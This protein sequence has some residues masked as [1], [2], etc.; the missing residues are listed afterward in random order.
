MN[1]PPTITS[2]ANRRRT[3]SL[4]NPQAPLLGTIG[5]RRNDRRRYDDNAQ[6][7]HRM[8]SVTKRKC[9]NIYIV[10]IA[11]YASIVALVYFSRHPEG[12]VGPLPD[13]TPGETHPEFFNPHTAWEHL[14]NI[15]TI[16]HAFNSRANT[17]VTRRYIVDQLK[18]LQQ[19]A[20]MLGRRNVRYDDQDTTSIHRIVKSK[21]QMEAEKDNGIDSYRDDTLESETKLFVQ[22]DNLL[23]WVGGVIP[24]QG[25]SP[26][27][28]I[29]FE[30]E[31]NALLVSSH[32][33]SVSTSYGATDDGGGVAVS[34][35]LIQHFIHHPVQHT[36]IFFFNNAEE[37]GL[38]GAETFM[39]ARDNKTEEYGAGHPWK[40]YIKAFINL[41]GGG[42]GGPSLLF[43][44]TGNDI[45][46]HYAANAP[47]PHAS[48]FANDLFATGIIDSDTDFT[49]YKKH[50]LP[51]LDIAF[52]QRRAMYHSTTDWLP[53]QSLHHMGSNAQATIR[54]ICNSDYLDRLV[55]DGDDIFS[56]SIEVGP[57]EDGL[58]ILIGLYRWFSGLSIYY[59]IFGRRMIV[60]EL[61]STL[62][63][64]SLVLAV[65]LPI[66]M[67][68]AFKIGW[69][70]LQSYDRKV[71]GLG[72][73]GPTGRHR[74]SSIS[75]NNT[76]NAHTYRL[77]AHSLRSVIDS[78]SAIN[79]SED[80]YSPFSSRN[81]TLNSNNYRRYGAAGD[82][83]SYGASVIPE[84]E[85]GKRY[86]RRVVWSMYIAP[87]IKTVFLIVIMIVLQIAAIVY[88]S[89]HLWKTN[90][91]VR[92]GQAWLTLAAFAMLVL[93]VQTFIIWFGTAFER[94]CYGSVPVIRAANQWT[95]AVA[96]WWWLIVIVVGTGVAGWFGVGAFYGTTVLAAFS[97][98]AA[99]IQVLISF[100][101]LDGTVD[102][103][104]EDEDELYIV[105]GIM[106]IPVLIPA[107]P[108]ISR[109][110][111]FKKMLLVEAL[112]T[113]ALFFYVVKLAEPFD[114]YN[115]LSLEYSQYYNQTARTSSIIMETPVGGGVLYEMIKF[116]PTIDLPL[117][118]PLAHGSTRNKKNKDLPEQRICKPIPPSQ[119]KDKSIYTQGDGC[120]FKPERQV[121][122]DEGWVK[123]VQVD[124][125]T[126]PTRIVVTEDGTR[127]REGQLRVLAYES[128][129]CVI[130][131]EQ[132]EPGRETEIWTIEGE[133]PDGD[134]PGDGGEGGGHNN[135]EHRH[136]VAH[137]GRST[138]GRNTEGR[139]DPLLPGG[140]VNHRPKA[141]HSFRREWNRTWYA[142]VRVKLNK[143]DEMDQVPGKGNEGGR[144]IDVYHL[145]PDTHQ[146]FNHNDVPNDTRRPLSSPQ[147]QQQ[148]QTNIIDMDSNVK[149]TQP[150]GERTGSMG[151]D[152]ERR[153]VFR[154]PIRVRCG[155][156]D[157]SSNQ[158][159]AEE[160]N[161]IRTHIPDWVRLKTRSRLGLF[162]VGVDLEF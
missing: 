68:V 145:H 94:C 127:W 105:Y 12:F 53:I 58:N 3:L 89:L 49:V 40:K 156:E 25:D 152:T 150:L 141:L 11:V 34:L 142:I 144:K 36:L 143:E 48:V 125:V 103:L 78:S 18:A 162:T 22:G 137:V 134:H 93:F 23:F 76:T 117:D 83:P 121:F 91:F 44:A 5:Q 8:H 135:T 111:H 92:Y 46:R 159:Y 71:G 84:L 54:G 101:T 28:E 65:G 64:N 6:R 107:V 56:N 67:L 51:G 13:L 123:P 129:Y 37:L 113:A 106:L 82:T 116:V 153:Q 29:G 80:G 126:S 2:R 98:L 57:R 120:E 102:P 47:H 155:Y 122:E 114:A 119:K 62:L 9:W 33:D 20:S 138:S 95:Y 31:Q 130:N 133:L 124:W 132:T 50:G 104:D 30:E 154:V 99:L 19:E 27:L 148:Q 77:P 43:R 55:M 72:R 100:A 74:S 131:V 160:F 147:H 26:A 161:D 112:L 60:M 151:Q 128:R 63:I 149:S 157:W 73:G 17:D 139:H 35:A 90:P 109:A 1:S 85:Y 59:D 16:P 42:S 61:W 24:P 52:Y 45:V 97:G 69:K 14:G 21:Q 108:V 136:S 66:L 88:A 146:S 70:L 39:G 140:I 32:Y 38:F 115:P 96:I 15:T 86:R 7:V 41:E 10:L 118:I 75:S 79:P 158:G 87:A 81:T 4:D 110:R